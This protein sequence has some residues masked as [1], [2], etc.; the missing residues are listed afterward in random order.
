MKIIK[1]KAYECSITP[2]IFGHMIHRNKFITFN[3]RCRKY[4]TSFDKKKVFFSHNFHIVRD[5][6]RNIFLKNLIQNV[7]FHNIS[8]LHNTCYGF[9]T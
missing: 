6:V 8:Y 3:L 4:K 9:Y 1:I 7:I 5:N 2:V